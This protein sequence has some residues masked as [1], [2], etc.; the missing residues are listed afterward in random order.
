VKI[1]GETANVASDLLVR[2][3]GANE[4]RTR[5]P[6]LAKSVQVVACRG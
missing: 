2:G 4:T 5:D 3:S 1:N 6:L